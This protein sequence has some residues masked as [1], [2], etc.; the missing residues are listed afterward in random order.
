ML[1][2]VFYDFEANGLDGVPIEVGFA[3]LN[4]Q[5]GITSDAWL[6]KPDPEWNLMSVWDEDAEEIHGIS[7]A[8]LMAE[9]QPPV[10]VAHLLNHELAG[11][12]LYSD[13]PFDQ[14]WM[15]QLFESAGFEPTFQIKGTLAPI[16]ID[17][18][19]ASLGFSED[20]V[21]GLYRRLDHEV[22]HKDRAE[23][24]ARHLAAI[25]AGLLTFRL[26]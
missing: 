3:F 10:Q 16:I 12:D 6:I 14:K 2:P 7:L 19:R 20:D 21:A 25:W 8:Q 1:N 11:R 22:P 4:D 26:A 5:H 9:G 17:Q 23:A 15:E 24:D 13:S 18:L